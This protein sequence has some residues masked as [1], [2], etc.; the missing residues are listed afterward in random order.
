MLKQSNTI[1]FINSI[2]ANIWEIKYFKLILV[3]SNLVTVKIII[4]MVNI[5]II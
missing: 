4:S 5:E 1:I 3:S 2:K